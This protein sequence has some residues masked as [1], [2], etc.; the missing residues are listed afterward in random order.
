[1][2]F[3]VL[4]TLNG[5]S[6]GLVLFL[7][8]SGLSITMGV[9]GILNLTHGALYMVGGYTGWMLA[10]RFGFNF[11]LGALAGGLVA[12]A[13]GLVIQR[14]FLAH[15]HGRLDEQ[16]LVTWGCVF[17]LTNL[18]TWIWTAEPRSPFTTPLLAGA[19]ELGGLTY[20]LTRIGLIVIGLV[21]AVALWWLQDR[22]HLGAMVRA[23]MDDPETAMALGVNLPLVSTA[24]F[25]LGAFVAGLSGVIGAQLIGVEPGQGVSILLLALVVVIVGGVGSIQGALLGGILIGL[26]D[27]FG[28]ALIPGVSTF[29][30]Y[31]AMIVI[32]LVRPSGLIARI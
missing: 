1:V 23:G 6:Y 4:N 10:V 3:V 27:A 28:A 15:L 21:L 26:V 20:P 19:L 22:T 2:S 12:A 5:V 25:V 31:L 16:V 17:I 8:A 30:I 24:V 9:M 18:S 7:L 14:M 29:L 32:L 11:W 13:I